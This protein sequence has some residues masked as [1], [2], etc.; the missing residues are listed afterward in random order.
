[1]GLRIK[2]DYFLGPQGLLSCP[3][4]PR[5]GGEAGKDRLH[6]SSVAS[7]QLDNDA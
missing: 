7:D 6:S 3:A 1:M 5:G 2:V 4:Y